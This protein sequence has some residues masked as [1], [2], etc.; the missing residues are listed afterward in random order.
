MIMKK[1][2]INVHPQFIVDKAGKKTGVVMD[3]ST[4]EELMEK[5][6]ELYLGALAEDVLKEED[7]F[8]ELKEIK[9]DL[10]S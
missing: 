3:I 7:T 8:Y 1:R 6:E 5:F 4:F 10:L 2:L 9:A